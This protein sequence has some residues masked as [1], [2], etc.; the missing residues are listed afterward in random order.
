M[1]ELFTEDLMTPVEM[2]AMLDEVTDAEL[3]LMLDEATNDCSEAAKSD[4]NSE[5]HQTCFA[6][7]WMLGQEFLRRGIDLRTLH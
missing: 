2:R 5:W 1:P 6:A 7:V 3:V 4:P